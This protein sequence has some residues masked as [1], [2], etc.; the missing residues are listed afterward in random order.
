V[1][2]ALGQVKNGG[3]AHALG[4]VE[5]RALG[6]RFGVN[7]EVIKSIEVVDPFTVQIAL[8]AFAVRKALDRPPSVRPEN[9]PGVTCGRGRAGP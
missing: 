9:R 4:D 8:K 6:M 7:L 5:N 1:P 3:P 2:H